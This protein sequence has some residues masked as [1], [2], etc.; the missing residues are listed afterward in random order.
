MCAKK[1]HK[2]NIMHGPIRTLTKVNCHLAVDLVPR[3]V[4]HIYLIAHCWE[5]S[6]ASSVLFSV[7]DM[8]ETFQFSV[9]MYI[10]TLVF[11]IFSIHHVLVMNRR[12][13]GP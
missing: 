4:H 8:K 6:T 11:I 12:P 9:L 2:D 3:P 13:V 7:P 5:E 1:T 10:P